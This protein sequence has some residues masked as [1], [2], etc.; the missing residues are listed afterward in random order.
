MFVGRFVEKKGLAAL[1]ELAINR[2]DC[3]FVLVGDG[4]I[5]P[6]SW[7]LQNVTLLG[8]RTR[9][10]LARLYRACDGLVLPS[11]GEGYPLVVQEALASGLSVYCGLDSAAADPGAMPFLHGV[12]V[13]PNNPDVAIVGGI[14]LFKTIDGG[15]TWK[16]ISK[17]YNWNAK[18]SYVHADQH[19]I[20]YKPNSSTTALFAN[21][22]GVFYTNNIGAADTAS[23]I[24]H[25]S[26]GY[27]VTQFYAAAIHPEIGK[28]FFLAG[29]QDNGTQR[30]TNPSFSNTTTATGGDGA[31]CF[32]DQ[33]NPKYQIASYVG[34]SY[35]LST[36][37][38]VSFNK[39][40]I[41]KTNLGSFINPA[42]YDNILHILYSNSSKDSLVRIKNITGIPKLEYV[43]V[44][45]LSTA[46]TALKVSPYNHMSTT[47]FLGTN[48][49]KL[50]KVVNA[51]SIPSSTL[52][53]GPSFPSGSI[54]CIE[55]GASEKELLV[56][57]FNYGS[58]KIWYTA[59]G[60]KN[61]VDKMGN[62]PDMP[63]RWALF[64]PN[65]ISSEVILATELGVY[66]TNNFQTASPSWTQS[67]N[68]FANVR[69]DMLQMR[70]ADYAV[71]A[72]TYGRGLYFNNAFSEAT[73][74]VISS[75]SPKIGIKGTKISIKGTNFLNASEVRF[76][77]LPALSFN[78]DS[79]TLITATIPDSA[80]DGTVRV[81]N[82]SHYFEKTGFKACATPKVNTS[83]LISFCEGGSVSLSISAATS[84][85]WLNL[86]SQKY[87]ISSVIFDESAKTTISSPSI[88]YGVK[89]SINL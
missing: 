60:G 64:N 19:A 34:N 1:R 30:F 76:G 16:Q 31:F 21:D 79:D 23:V 17:W 66:A 24:S 9:Q 80:Q 13:D 42:T 10:E 2:P 15:N 54:S 45:N 46:V 33:S 22:G 63:V 6:A 69:T 75:F 56:T 27:N 25:A 47:L 5:N 36:D 39:M 3:E 12:A 84:V 51:D 62:F 72:S 49:G 81:V 89:L 86:D 59:D 40:L 44:P 38:G 43:S 50:L 77:G 87:L 48:T 57:F 53:G 35:Y 18:Y 8:R 32:I 73:P 37:T 61:W 7:G 74:P 71:I 41:S 26:K 70:S 88:R 55:I 85:N 78:V 68:G 67:N 58:K 83:G 52:I 11:I 20:L 65:K 14:D 4:P 82:E 28:N 29:S